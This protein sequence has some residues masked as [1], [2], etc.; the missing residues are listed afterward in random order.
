MQTDIN[1][2]NHFLIAMPQLDDPNFFHSVT[3]ICQHDAEG[4]MGIIINRP[5]EMNMG[6]VFSSL[7]INCDDDTL[8]QQ[9]LYSGG[10][11]QTER[12]F[13]LHRPG[14]KW[15]ATLFLSDE[16]ALT[17]SSDILNDI[18]QRNGPEDTLVA[19]GYAGWGAGQLEQE[20]TDNIWLSVSADPDIIF[21]LPINQ[22]WHAAATLLGVDLQFL[23]DDIGH[24]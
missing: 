18:A 2:T 5:L 11:V 8:K 1:L 23:S 14:K 3:Y 15:Q 24:A 4:T 10:P 20:I 12:G 21:N 17:T 19:L 7:K 16:I 13:V 6:E 9:A 22:R